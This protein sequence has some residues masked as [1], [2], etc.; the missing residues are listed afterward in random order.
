MGIFSKGKANIMIPK[1]GYLPGETISGTV[2]LAVDKPVLAKEFRVSLVGEQKTTHQRRDSDGHYT[3]ETETKRVYDFKQQLDG[4]KEYSGKKEYS[5]SIKVPQDI[6]ARTQ[7]LQLEGTAGQV[8]RFA[9]GA[10]AMMGAIPRTN[11]FV[12]ASLDIPKGFD[13]NKKVDITIG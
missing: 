1:T 12:E 3:T 4:E 11:W 9:Q 13:V 8:F 6:L 5:F 10:A 2:T 7:P